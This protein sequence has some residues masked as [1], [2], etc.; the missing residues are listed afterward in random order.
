MSEF[1]Q[2][3]AEPGPEPG[4]IPG[5]RA[6]AWV[7]AGVWG[8]LGAALLLGLF[9][10]LD[11][12]G[13]RPLTIDE[14]YF[15][16]AVE[17]IRQ[18]G[19]PA[20][21]SGGYYVRGLLQ[22]YLTAGAV[23]A[24]GES[25]A[26]L[27]LPALLFGLASVALAVA[28]AR[29]FL[30][31]L[32]AA[33]VGALVLVSSW[34]VEFARFARM[35]APFQCATLAFLVALHAA[36]VRG[37]WR[38][39]Y[40]PHALV[41]VAALTHSLAVLLVPWLFLPFALP[42]RRR[43][44]GGW[45]GVRFAALG[46][47]TGL[48]VLAWIR[49]DWAGV[50]VVGS[51]PVGYAPPSSGPVRMAMA[52]LWSLGRGPT[53]D[54]AALA[55]PALLWLLWLGARGELRGT[56]GW[57]SAWL[58]AAVVAAVSHQLALAATCLAVVAVRWL[59][60]R[61]GPWSRRDRLLLATCAAAAAGWLAWVLW[62]GGRGEGL[63]LLF[64]FPDYATPLLDP[65]WGALKRMTLLL[66]A[67][68]AFDVVRHGSD[69]LSELLPR[70]TSFALYAILCVVLLHSNVASVRYLYFAYPVALVVLATAAREA[71][72]LVAAREPRLRRLLADRAA[73]AALGTLVAFAAGDDFFLRHLTDPA[74]RDASYRLHEF[75]RFSNSRGPWYYRA[76]FASPARF[77]ERAAEPGARI[78]LVDQ[79]PVSHYLSHEHAVY[80]ARGSHRFDVHSRE[81]GTLD[82]FSGHLLLS[83]PEE[84]RRWT[85]AG[86]TLWLVRRTDWTPLDEDA[87]FR[88]RVLARERMEVG[89]DGRIEVVRLVLRPLEP[90]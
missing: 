62:S 25:E 12:F 45:A 81:R 34:E 1:S 68:L 63:R 76:D 57:R 66:G 29:A 31:R 19:L 55:L 28:Y 37:R 84:V 23:L 54:A 87:A 4:A 11:G 15:A 73:W 75:A 24:W 14:Y 8:L 21:P 67:A 85:A 2:R 22:Q 49:I 50:G 17:W 6:G 88:G 72:D 52:P 71:V 18:S 83:T 77:L 56:A 48:V 10:R 30:P 7:R 35:Y 20:I 44:L 80:Y 70:P 78:L 9:A 58:G 47:A 90:R 41:V 16:R 38:L 13:S 36:Y 33:T 82:L 53:V 64:A 61:R 39:R 43:A 26:M 59:P 79:P 60:R 65:W 46:L 69:P 51:Y 42:E 74:G 89:E 5:R 3:A 40:L 27:R 32:L 86:G